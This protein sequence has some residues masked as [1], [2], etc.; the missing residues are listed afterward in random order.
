M[1]VFAKVCPKCKHVHRGSMA[2][3]GSPYGCG[4][5]V[6]PEVPYSYRIQDES[7]K[8]FTR[9]GMSHMSI[10]CCDVFEGRIDYYE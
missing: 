5:G 9:S 3:G 7:G 8:W 2:V 10:C 6:G 1:N 4:A